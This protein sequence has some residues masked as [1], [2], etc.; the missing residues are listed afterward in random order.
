M[1]KPNRTSKPAAT[2]NAAPAVALP[3]TTTQ[4]PAATTPAASYG[5]PFG[6]PAQIAAPFGHAAKPVS[7]PTYNPQKFTGWRVVVYGTL[8]NGN[9]KGRR[10]VTLQGEHT[11]QSAQDWF[12]ANGDS[13]LTHFVPGTTKSPQYLAPFGQPGAQVVKG[14]NSR[15]TGKV[16]SA[17]PAAPQPAAL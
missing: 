4:A 6:Q 8:L 10:V 3:I 16:R 1:A 15:T 2:F 9:T 7:G 13:M 12:A 11:L 17:Q 14:P 5:A